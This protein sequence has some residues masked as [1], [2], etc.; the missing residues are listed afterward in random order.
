VLSLGSDDSIEQ[1]RN[2]LAVGCSAAVLLEA[3][4][5]AYGPADVAQAIAAVVREHAANGTNYELV[6]LGNDAADTGDF[7]VPVRLAYELDRPVLTGISTVEVVG[8]Q[9]NAR[10]R[11]TEG[12]EI[13]ELAL[14]AVVAVMEG[15]VSP[16]YPSIRGRMAAKKVAIEQS[17][18]SLQ[19]TG[20]ARL[21]LILPPSPPSQVEILGEGPDA[22]PAVVELLVRLGVT[23]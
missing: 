16:R 11:G 14:P 10:G 22:A 17:E 8:D 18:P 21:K 12:P 6:L 19:P 13:Y 5:G 3:D 1:L 4:A 9:I 23:R 15:G 20:N 7:Q 2:A